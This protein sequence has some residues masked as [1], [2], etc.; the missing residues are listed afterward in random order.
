MHRTTPTRA[1]RRPLAW[2]CSALRTRALEDRLST[3]GQSRPAC[4]SIRSRCLWARR[5]RRRC[6]IDRARSRLRDNHA[7]SRSAAL[8]RAVR[9][10]LLRRGLRRLGRLMR[11]RS[12]W[13]RSRGLLNH[14]RCRR[15]FRRL[16][17]WRYCDRSFFWNFRFHNRR[18][19]RLLNRCRLFR[20][21]RR[22]R[23]WCFRG[24]RRRSRLFDL[25]WRNNNR[26]WT[27]GGD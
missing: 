4:T 10:R 3:N 5:W 19:R 21:D 12:Y 26:R 13:R 15:R 11:N 18:W 16:H 27:R 24:G 22:F 6:G 20:C 8:T 25:R 7:P 14:R 17:L 9:Y 23:R 1:H 2:S